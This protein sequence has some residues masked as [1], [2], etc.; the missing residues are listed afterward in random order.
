MRTEL[1]RESEAWAEVVRTPREV[2][3]IEAGWIMGSVAHV[4]YHLGAMRQIE[5][6]ARGPS[7]EDEARIEAEL[8]GS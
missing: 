5:R 8:R 6:T 4:A 1:R 3:E 7:A 2:S